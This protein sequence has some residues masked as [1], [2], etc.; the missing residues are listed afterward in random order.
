MRGDGVHRDLGPVRPTWHAGP[1]AYV[2]GGVSPVG[3]PGGGGGDGDPVP[4]PPLIAVPTWRHHDQPVVQVP[5]RRVIGVAKTL[6]Q[7]VSQ[8]ASVWQVAGRHTTLRGGRERIGARLRHVISSV[9]NRRLCSTGPRARRSRPPQR[10]GTHTPSGPAVRL[11]P[12]LHGELPLFLNCNDG[13][14]D[15][16]TDQWYESTYGRPPRQIP[17]RPR[18]R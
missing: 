9:R 17:A 4:P 13:R 7:H 18:L 10:T 5:Y 6:A 1:G 8:P 15:E 14:N 2:A 3:G 16:V 12:L 11:L